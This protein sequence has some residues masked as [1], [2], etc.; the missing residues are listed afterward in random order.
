M[1]RFKPTNYD[2]IKMVPVDFKS[3]LAPGTF[4]YTLDY[5]I[6]EQ[7]DLSIFDHQY[8]NDKTGATAYDPKVLLKIV[9]LAYSRGI[10]SSR[11][12][13]RLCRENIIFIAI[14]CDSQPHFTTIAD[15]IS[16]LP[17]EIETIFRDVLLICDDMGLI[18]KQMFAID[19]CKIPSNA[20]K[21][22]SG[23]RKQFAEKKK[24]MEGVI[25]RIL[26]KHRDEDSDDQPPPTDM[27]KREE[28]QIETIKRKARKY[29]QWLKENTDKPGKRKRVVQSNITDN[30]SAKLKSAGGVIQGY[31]GL[32]ISDQMHQV[33]VSADI[34]GQNDERPSL[35]PMVEKVR[36]NLPGD[37]PFKSG[38]FSGDSGFCDESNLKFLSDNQI[39][40]Y[41]PDLRFRQRDKRFLNAERYYP[42]ERRKAGGK[43][44]PKDFIVDPN[45]E[46]VTCPAGKKIWMKSRNPKTYGI[47]AIQYQAHVADCKQCSLKRRCWRDE[48]Q[49]SPRQF[50]WFQTHLPEHQ[51][52]TKRMKEKIDSEEGRY[53]Y[54]KRLAIIEPVFA[55]ITSTIGL[56]RFSL[57]GKLKVTAQWLV[58]CLVHNIGKIQRYGMA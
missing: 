45:K 25:R 50:T 27:R 11:Q 22:W 24:K 38:K 41:I 31:N 48:N 14:S 39:D 4:E 6:D 42:K 30:E 46:T 9:L 57:R 12:I 56:D 10:T 18:G 35:K 47:P 58:F 53:E 7:L 26:K 40:S 34:A 52:Y 19:G 2:Q 55:N 1:P 32:A 44:K 5:L 28:K 17:T 3:Q 37:D 15:F 29:K 36:H 21:E 51:T 54:S 49:K 13:E 20:S 16:K 8:N 23:T 33:I 43:F